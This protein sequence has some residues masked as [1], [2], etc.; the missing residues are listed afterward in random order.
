MRVV[1]HCS[2]LLATLAIGTTIEAQRS[3]PR[4]PGRAAMQLLAELEQLETEAA[5]NVAALR[6]DAF[7]VAQ[8]AAA[9]GELRDF[10]KSVAVQKALDRV[11]ASG[12][13]ASERPS[14]H[15]EVIRLLSSAKA[16]LTKAREQGFSTDFPALERDLDTIS[17]DIQPWVF[18]DILE[19]QKLRMALAEIQERVGRMTRELDAATGE[20][21]VSTLEEARTGE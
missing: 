4:M 8:L 18:R 9:T 15:P 14:A 10:Q 3:Q 2:L 12:R 16:K 13:R 21:L 19:M 6:R 17:A 20:V 7:I 5:G 1:I 11:D